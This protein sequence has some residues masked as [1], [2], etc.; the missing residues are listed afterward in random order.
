MPE[1]RVDSSPIAGRGLFAVESLPAGTVVLRPEAPV[2]ETGPVNHA[3]DPNLGWAGDALVA[4]R[5]VAAGEELVV[6]YAMSTADPDWF[7]RCH[8]PSYRCR[9]MVEGTDWRIP[10]LQARYAGHWAPEVQRL[11]DSG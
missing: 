11:V 9:Q 1:L 4:L 7:L 2:H 5:D 3:C 8:C 10:Q 6:D